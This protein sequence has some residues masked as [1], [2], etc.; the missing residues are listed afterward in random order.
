MMT[1]FAIA[2]SNG[3]KAVNRREYGYPHS[4][5]RYDRVVARPRS[6]RER[7]LKLTIPADFSL[8][9][10]PGEALEPRTLT[11]TYFDTPDRA[12]ARAGVTLR[13]RV[14][15]RKGVWQLK[16]PG[17]GDR[18]ELESPGGTAAPPD[19][20]AE[21]LVGLLRGRELERAAVL[22]TRRTGLRAQVDGRTV[23]DVTVDKVSILDGRRVR[24]SFVELEVEALDGDGAEALPDLG[25]ALE[26]AGAAEGDGRPK[27]FRAMGF[28]PL[29]PA[30]P[31]PDAPALEHVRAALAR[32]LEELVAHDPG[33]RFGEDPEELHQLRVATR[34]LR[35][36]LRAARDLLDPTW[37]EPLRAELSWLGSALGPV[38]DL[39]V[40]TEHLQA[41]IES[42]EPGER[43][44][45]ARFVAH[46]D[47]DRDA[48]RAAMLE[49]MS[50]PRY[51]RLLDRLD[52]A[53]TAPHAREADLPLGEIAAAEFRKLRK[54]V[55]ALPPDPPDDELHAVRIRGKRARYAAELAEG[56]VGK[57]A[58]RFVKDAKRFQD[59]VGEHQDAV[60]AEERIRDLLGRTG[61][62]QA[63]L[64]AG[65]LIERE[66]RRRRDARE[67]F[68]EAWEALEKSGKK[69]WA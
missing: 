37:S 6:T 41:E 13:R 64:A 36:I 60:V 55:K 23:A 33:T 61:S 8:P 40:L 59:V 67:A 54:A 24:E 19:D 51:F 15:N 25:R 1:R 22:R 29:E 12:L 2:R 21:L 7:E 47:E 17:K 48:A 69:A 27:A 4:F 9:E 39:D 52:V 63:Y 34:R 53:A 50:S 16:L 62:A 3:D 11:S 56:A 31:P 26:D 10:L 49:A 42:L 5:R 58:Q 14:E 43:R 44:A 32:Q 38:R 68:P 20:L 65:R 57:P 66:R 46:L 28:F 45:A 30:A 18:L 35:A